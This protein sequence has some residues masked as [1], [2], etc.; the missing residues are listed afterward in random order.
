MID[1]SEIIACKLNSTVVKAVVIKVATEDVRAVVSEDAKGVTEIIKFEV[2]TFFECYCPAYMHP[3]RTGGS[4]PG[5]ALARGL[6]CL[7]GVRCKWNDE[8]FYFA[9]T[10][11]E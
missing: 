7:P 9:G 6:V 2:T 3:Q 4:H 5:N 1:Y 8:I 11:L 10:F